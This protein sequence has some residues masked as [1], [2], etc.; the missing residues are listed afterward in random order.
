MS[1]YPRVHTVADVLI[2][3]GL[4]AM[5]M[6]IHIF[7]GREAAWIIALTTLVFAI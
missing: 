1:V 2:V 3:S 6:A 4:V 7:V 5:L